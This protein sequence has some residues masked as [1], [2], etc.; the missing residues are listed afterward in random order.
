MVD[1]SS[2]VDHGA[3]RL[4]VFSFLGEYS[5]N[6]R[7]CTRKVFPRHPFGCFGPTKL[8]VQ[9]RAN[10]SSSRS[11]FKRGPVTICGSF[12]ALRTPLR[13]TRVSLVWLLII[14]LG[15]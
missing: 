6:S 15:K 12:T 1:L 9:H 3:S 5:S 13:V 10:I 2:L 11:L 8:T 14:S 7:C 4:L